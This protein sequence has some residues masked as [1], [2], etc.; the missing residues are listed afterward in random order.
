[1]ETK[2]GRESSRVFNL[3]EGLLVGS[4]LVDGISTVATGQRISDCIPSEALGG[5]YEGVTKLGP[6]LC[7]LTNYLGRVK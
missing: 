1:M 7:L 2:Q 4:V 5:V 6:A 3:L